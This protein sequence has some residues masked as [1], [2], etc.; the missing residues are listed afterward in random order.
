MGELKYEC[1]YTKG[2][3]V[4]EWTSYVVMLRPVGIDSVGGEPLLY[5]PT[6]CQNTDTFYNIRRGECK[7]WRTLRLCQRPLYMC[8]NVVDQSMPTRFFLFFLSVS[9]ILT[10]ALPLWTGHDDEYFCTVTSRL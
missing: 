3:I 1:Q 5:C 9:I 8:I 10:A 7:M 4:L 2:Q 6:T